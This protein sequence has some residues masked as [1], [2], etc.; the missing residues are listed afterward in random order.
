M[1]RTD[2]FRN[3]YQGEKFTIKNVVPTIEWDGRIG[4]ME[5]EHTNRPHERI[6]KRYGPGRAVGQDTELYVDRDIFIPKQHG[7]KIDEHRRVYVTVFVHDSFMRGLAEKQR[8][9]AVRLLV[10]KHAAWFFSY[11]ERR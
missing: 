10:R 2:Q 11:G 6:S 3:K 8:T 4:E 7:F 1:S 5:V 9:E